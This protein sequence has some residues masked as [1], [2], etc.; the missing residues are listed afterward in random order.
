MSLQASARCDMF[1]AFSELRTFPLSNATSC[2]LAPTCPQIPAYSAVLRNRSG[3]HCLP[4]A[5]PA[6][7]SQTR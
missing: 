5:F 7:A 2:R 1:R 6:C 4:A 3:A